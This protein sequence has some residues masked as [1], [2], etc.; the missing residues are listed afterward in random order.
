MVP[1]PSSNGFRGN[2]VTATMYDANIIALEDQLKLGKTYVGSNATIKDN[3]SQFRSSQEDKIWNITG[4]T[5]IEELNMNNLNFLL[6]KYKLTPFDK[7]EKHIDKNVNIGITL[8]TKT[9]SNV[10]IDAGIIAVTNYKEWCEQTKRNWMNSQKINPLLLQGYRPTGGRVEKWKHDLYEE[11][12][13]SPTPKNEEDQIAKIE[14][15]LAS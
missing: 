12:N 3:K 9:N 1:K 8:S 6:S 15:L 5:K 14:A 11:S 2:E 7:L 10:F 13:R 4:K